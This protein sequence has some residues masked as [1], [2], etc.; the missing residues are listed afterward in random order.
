MI[1]VID[2]HHHLWRYNAEE[3]G[4]IDEPMAALRR[5]FLMEDLAPELAAAGVDGTVVVQARQSME[6]TQWLCALAAGS[7][8]IR[9]V[10]GWA[11]VAS[12]KFQGMLEEL[13]SMERLVGLRHVVQGEASGFLDGADFNRGVSLL[14]DA[15]LTYDILILQSQLA[16]AIRFVDRHPA[17]AFVVDHA[18]KPRIAARETEPWRTHL[19]ELGRRPNVMCKVSGMVTEAEWVD[20]GI[21]CLREY[22]DVCVESF[23]AK[24]MMAGSDW[25]VCLMA[26]SYVGWWELLREYFK[27]FDGSERAGILG[28]NAV[29]FYGL[30]VPMMSEV[31]R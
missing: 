24:R 11:P 31:S 9:G 14:A 7:S 12:P 26:S 5:D 6:E 30:T 18:A 22:L 27:G 15:G 25:P 16:E 23:G 8:S 17:Q 2:A 20:C 28:G 4:W 3:F 13:G 1:P 10:V 29:D 21:N 19:R